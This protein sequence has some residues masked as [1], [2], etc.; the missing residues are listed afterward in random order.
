MLWK[1]KRNTREGQGQ[2]RR[3]RIEGGFLEGVWSVSW[4][5]E[6]IHRLFL[7]CVLLCSRHLQWRIQGGFL[8]FLR[9]PLPDRIN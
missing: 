6:P 2:G 5:I 4:L 1:Q 8:G 9:T 7:L 3:G